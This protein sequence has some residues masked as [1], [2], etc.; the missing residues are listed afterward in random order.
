MRALT[1]GTV[2]VLLLSGC[3]RRV[4][5]TPPTNTLSDPPP[6]MVNV[7]VQSE[8]G[9][10][11]QVRTASERC[12]TPCTAQVSDAE[13]LR[14][15]NKNDDRILVPAL[16][17]EAPNTQHVMLVAEGT[18]TGEQANGIVFTTLG[19]MALVTGITLTAVGCSNTAE[20]GGMCTA[21]LITGGVALPLTAF[22]IWLIVDAQPKAHV[23][24][25]YKS[26]SKI[27]VAATP[28]GIVGTF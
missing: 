12:V 13:T 6:G 24:P 21:G 26:D 23:I 4:V 19:G 2:L 9:Q 28:L 17:V 5:L 14:L 16:A 27:T 8:D 20:R 1:L 3:V 18:H 22:A 10:Q 7:S 15:M 25:I 11:W